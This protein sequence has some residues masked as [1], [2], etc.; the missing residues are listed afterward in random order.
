MMFVR[1][2]VVTN[3]GFVLFLFVFHLQLFWC[4]GSDLFH[5]CGISWHP[6][7]KHAYSNILKILPPKTE[8][9]QK[10]VLILFIRISA[11]KHRL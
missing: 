11:Q 8:S 9:F 2:F 5:D 10:K 4:L 6:L 7:R 1:A 3:K